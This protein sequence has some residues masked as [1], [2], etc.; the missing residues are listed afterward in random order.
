LSITGVTAGAAI[1]CFFL[2]LL[3]AL[4]AAAAPVEAGTKDRNDTKDIFGK[5]LLG[6]VLVVC[7]HDDLCAVFFEY[8]LDKVVCEAA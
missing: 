6:G 7:F 2:L 8:V 1:F 5:L 4:A 3:V